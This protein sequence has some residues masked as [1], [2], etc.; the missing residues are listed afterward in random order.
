MCEQ[1]VIPHAN[2]QAPRN[3]PHHNAKDQCFPREEKNRGERAQVQCDHNCR[4]APIDG[5][6]ESSIV[7]QKIE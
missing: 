2:A 7:F 6:G 3:P 1:P 4:N 5:L